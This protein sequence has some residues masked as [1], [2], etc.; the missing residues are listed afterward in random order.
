M[1]SPGAIKTVVL[2]RLR[3]RAERERAQG[4]LIP[5]EDNFHESVR[6]KLHGLWDAPQFWNFSRCGNEDCFRTCKDCRTIT[7]LPYHC[8][9]KWCPR[10]QWKI[11]DTRKKVLQL[12]TQKIRQPKHLVLTQKNFP[13]LTRRRLREHTRAL[14]RLRK[15]RC[16][17]N[18]NGG[19]VSVE[20]TN[21]GEGWHLHSHWLLDVRWLDMEKVSVAWG[22][23]VGQN[24]AVVKIK[25]CRNGEYLQEVSK[26]VVE[27]SELASWPAEKINEFVRAVKGLRFFFSFG[28]LLKLAPSI[29]A[30]L[31]AQKA[32]PPICECGSCNFVYEND[33]DHEVRQIMEMHRRKR[34]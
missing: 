15:K 3:A 28:S 33:C 32:P 8:N 12:W 16:F 26:Y 25:D 23:L 30:E 6:A 31:L 21:E 11:T 20:V 17:Q 13:I 9:V 1:T 19:C 14:S 2:A 18:V 24:F 7:K 5:D 22:K 34:F 10:C 29:R 27:G 4:R